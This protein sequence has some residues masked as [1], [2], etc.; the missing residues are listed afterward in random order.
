MSEEVHDQCSGD[1]NCP[2]CGETDFDA[3]GLK[4]HLL[5]GYCKEFNSIVDVNPYI[6][7]DSESDQESE[8]KGSLNGGDIYP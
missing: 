3:L 6:C 4:H 2:F 8:G 7:T 5:F 1:M